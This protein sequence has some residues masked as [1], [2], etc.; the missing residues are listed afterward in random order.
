M[1]VQSIEDFN[2]FNILD[3]FD[4]QVKTVISDDVLM[5][6][7]SDLALFGK[8]FFPNIFSSDYCDF[9]REVFEALETNALKRID[10][11]YYFVRAAPRSHAKSQIISFLY[12]IWCI[13]HQYAKNILIVSDTA[14][15]ATQFIMAIKDE[16]EENENLIK[17][18]GNKVGRSIWSQSRIVTSDR[19]QITAKGAG[20]KLRGIKYRHYRPDVIVVDDL[21]NDTAIESPTQRE[22][23]RSWFQKALIP[24]GSINVKIFYIGTVLSYE[25]LLNK[26]LTTPEY[27]MWDRKKFQ[28]VIQ[29]SQSPLW[30]KWEALL[31]DEG[32]EK[33]SEHAEAFYQ[34]H[35]DAM[36]KNT[37]LLWNAKQPDYY[38]DLMLIKV[39][40][41]ES[42]D[43]EYQNDPISDSTRDFREEWFQFWTLP[44]EITGVYIGVDPSLAKSNKSDT[45]SIVVV[46][47]GKD[48][49]CYVLEASIARRKPDKII[50]DLISKCI[51]YQ[52]KLIK[53]GIEAIQFQS[54]FAQECGKRGLKAGIAIPIEPITNMTD[55]TL[56]LKGLIPMIKN[57]Y[58]KF[59]TSQTTL[60][61]EFKQFPKGK[62]DGMDGLKMAID[63]IF[64]TMANA[65]KGLC[66]GSLTPLG[67]RLG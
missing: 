16:L 44:P 11:K 8:T 49:F 17:C 43:S 48:G 59:H 31:R 10:K 56:R 55:K 21:E 46:G 42:F 57:G 53:V 24:C 23:L 52:D 38:R 12:P 3:D 47:K 66:F 6:C 4:T 41:N 36:L 37:K 58:I 39:M 15:Q 28:A 51:T 22:K 35:K 40:D 30:E 33:A 25:S 18:Y 20:Q 27:A 14:E 2:V 60:L 65:A 7:R 45:S 26:M 1:E 13:V 50:D 9:H 62:D 29:F 54:F 32:D 63:L 19:I 34:K 67:R 61:N 5:R 64:P